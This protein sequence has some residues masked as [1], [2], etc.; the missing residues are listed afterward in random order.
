M[1]DQGYTYCI[2]DDSGHVKIGQAVRPHKRVVDLQTGNPRPLRL[3]G[4][5]EGTHHERSLHSK[6]SHLRVCGEWF[7]ATDEILSEFKIQ[8]AEPYPV[9]LPEDSKGP[10]AS[11]EDGVWLRCPQ[12]PDA[13]ATVVQC[14]LDKRPASWAAKGYFAVLRLVCAAEDCGHM[15]EL[16]FDYEIGSE[17]T[18]KKLVPSSCLITERPHDEP[19]A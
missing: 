7:K 1:G 9:M 5:I 18:V 17:V 10:I 3:Y 14:Y 15:F 13:S 16:S 6:Y 2:T 12:C 11:D 8:D 19:P 4:V